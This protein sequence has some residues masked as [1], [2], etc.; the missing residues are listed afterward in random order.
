MISEPELTGEDG[1]PLKWSG[2]SVPGRHG[3][4]RYDRYDDRDMDGDESP[5]EEPEPS[6]SGHPRPRK[7]LW[8]L[9]GAVTASALWAAGLYAYG[10]REPDVGKYRTSEDLCRDAELTAVNVAFGRTQTGNPRSHED[11]AMD[12]AICWL[13]FETPESHS[14]VETVSGDVSISYTLHRRTDP[15]PQFDAA[16]ALEYVF[17]DEDVKKVPVD[18]LGERAFFVEPEGVS[19]P[20]LQVL[21]GQA[22]LSMHINLPTNE[23]GEPV[24]PKPKQVATVKEVLVD[25]MRAL[26][27]KLQS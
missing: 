14:S 17:M 7:W 21:D 25:D 2:P 3:D 9:G 4:D 20:E 5:G 16:L 6:A 22:V 15:G 26:M 13:E 10:E 8:A 24:D 18:G 19:L 27:A 11:P 12:H 23:N 1:E